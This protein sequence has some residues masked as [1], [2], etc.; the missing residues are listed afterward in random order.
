MT[1]MTVAFSRHPVVNSA[2]V[3]RRLIPWRISGSYAR[4]VCPAFIRAGIRSDAADVAAHDPDAEVSRRAIIGP[5]VPALLVESTY[6][7]PPNEQWPCL[8]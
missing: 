3:A 1:A 8:I 4:L 5:E 7:P 2:Q 6:P